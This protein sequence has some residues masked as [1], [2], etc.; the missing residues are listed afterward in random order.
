MSLGGNSTVLGT[1]EALLSASTAVLSRNEV[2]L[3]VPAFGP[4][5]INR[6]LGRLEPYA[7]VDIGHS[8]ADPADGSIG[9]TMTG[10][11]AGLR[12]RGG[13][14]NFDISYARILSVTGAPQPESGLFQARMSVKF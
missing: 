12:N 5:A 11:V 10:A 3:D 13:R 1:R 4:D 14:L 2:S 9:G 6:T 7:G 8:Q